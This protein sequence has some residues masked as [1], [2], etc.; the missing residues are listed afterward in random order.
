MGGCYISEKYVNQIYRYQKNDAPTWK[1]SNKEEPVVPQK[2]CPE[3]IL[4]LPS[5]KLVTMR[6]KVSSR[7]DNSE[8]YSL[9]KVMA[10][11]LQILTFSFPIVVWGKFFQNT[12]Q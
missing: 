4:K 12:I 7:S 10:K 3:D 5:S 9:V 1:M 11:V 2:Q 8:R 6:M